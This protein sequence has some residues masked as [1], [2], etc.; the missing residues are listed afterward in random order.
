MTDKT[1]NYTKE[2]TEQLVNEYRAAESDA[3]R[4]AVVDA[5]AQEFGKKPA[6]V[7]A[8]LSSLNEYIKPAAVTK[9]GEPVVRKAQL[10]TQIA[11]ALELDEESIGSMEK[12]TKSALHKV[13]K[14]ATAE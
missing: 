3:D 2:Q 13:L 6:S 5:I 8:K 11:E 4:K 1:P 7:R 10:V 14:A 12:A 9:N